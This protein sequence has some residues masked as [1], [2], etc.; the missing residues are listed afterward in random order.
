PTRRS[1]DL[2]FKIGYFLDAEI[3]AFTTY[4]KKV[5]LISRSA[6]TPLNLL[7][8][9]TKADTSISSINVTCGAL[10]F[11]LTIADAIARRIP[12][13]F[14]RVSGYASPDGAACLLTASSLA[15]GS[16]ASAAVASV[17]ET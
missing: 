5:N 16:S 3:N 4:G 10:V 6:A 2:A 8:W 1:S 17:V 15:A 13:I 12:D 7:R 14:S 11:E 9:S